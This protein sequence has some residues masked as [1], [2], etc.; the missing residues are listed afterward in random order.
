MAQPPQRQDEQ[1]RGGQVTG[2]RDVLGHYGRLRSLNMR[3]MRSVIRN[4]DT[5]LI[6]DAATAI[7]PSTVVNVVFCSPAIIRRADHRN[8]RDRVG[9]RHERCVQQAGDVLNDL[10]AD[11][12]R[13]QE[14]E[15]HRPEI[16]RVQR[17]RSR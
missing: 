4:P 13:E 3:S 10:K 7:V 1:R 16:E 2:L 14:N 6:I 8:R 9:Q 11:E 15:G 12:C 17:C 5:M